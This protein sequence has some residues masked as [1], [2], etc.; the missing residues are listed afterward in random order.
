[1]YIFFCT[2]HFCVGV[3]VSKKQTYLTFLR[4]PTQPVWRVGVVVGGVGVVVGAG[5]AGVA[6]GAGGAG[7][8]GVASVTDG[9]CVPTATTDAALGVREGHHPAPARS[10]SPGPCIR[11]SQT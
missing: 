4:G 2:N 7:V 9:A 11:P 3:A 8:T 6:G 5:G 10:L 1:M